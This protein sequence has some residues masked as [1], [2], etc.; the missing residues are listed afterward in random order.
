MIVA[1][2]TIPLVGKFLFLWHHPEEHVRPTPR[3]RS[4]SLGKMQIL[5]E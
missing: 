5:W 1:D 3:E 2:I 4:L